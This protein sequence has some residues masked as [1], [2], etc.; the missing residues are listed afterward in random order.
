M[1]R[2]RE[3]LG[4]VFRSKEIPLTTGPCEVFTREMEV[5]RGHE[6]PDQVVIKQDGVEKRVFDFKHYG[7]RDISVS[8]DG[9]VFAIA[10]GGKIRIFYQDRLHEVD[11]KGGGRW[12][13]SSIIPDYISMD[14]VAVSNDGDYLVFGR[15]SI[16]PYILHGVEIELLGPVTGNDLSIVCLKD[17]QK[18][19]IQSSSLPG[20]YGREEKPRVWEIDKFH[21][22]DDDQHVVVSFKGYGGVPSEERVFSIEDEKFGTGEGRYQERPSNSSVGLPIPP[23]SSIYRVD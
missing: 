13:K 10:S 7:I 11:I 21:F 20:L 19:I 14:K 18:Y 3:I 9:H 5:H 1:S 2:F 15:K 16:A 4:R 22:S 12:V 8:D 6:L 23:T 17:M